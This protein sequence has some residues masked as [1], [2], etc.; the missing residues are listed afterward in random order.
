MEKI[1]LWDFDGVLADSLRE[2]YIVTAR[3]VEKERE[4]LEK[5][6]G[7]EP[8]PYP[9]QEFASDRP[10]CINAADFFV[11]YIARRK[12]GAVGEAQRRPIL[13]QKQVLHKLDEEYYQTRAAYAKELKGTYAAQLPPYAEVLDTLKEL[14]ENGVRQAIM[15]ARDR[16]S[17]REWLRYYRVEECIE[18][19]VGT[20]V[21][22]A[23]TS[24][25]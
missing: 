2:C 9:L 24:I 11:N 5:I 16:E 6:I 23:V 1:V 20:E 8:A 7:K 25:P 13:E 12:Y 17:V 15:T 4:V 14:K 19:I 18:L 21:S 10:V 22:R 3:V